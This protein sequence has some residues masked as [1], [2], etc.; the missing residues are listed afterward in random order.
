M[1]FCWEKYGSIR[2]LIVSMML[3]YF[4]VPVQDHFWTFWASN[5]LKFSIQNPLNLIVRLCFSSHY[6]ILPIHQKAL[7]YHYLSRMMS[8]WSDD[9]QSENQPLGWCEKSLCVCEC[10]AMVKRLR[11]WWVRHHQWLTHFEGNRQSIGTWIFFIQI[12]EKQASFCRSLE[13][14][15]DLIFSAEIVWFPPKIIN[16]SN[17]TS[18]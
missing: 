3:D 7:C 17:S 1:V 12:F 14:S 4:E 2:H 5:A 16:C 10:V 15:T 18:N 11:Q 9:H 13:I 6:S 8:S